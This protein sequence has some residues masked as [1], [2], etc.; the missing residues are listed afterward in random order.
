MG[1]KVRNFIVSISTAV[2][3]FSTISVLKSGQ[4]GIERTTV[5]Y[6]EKITDMS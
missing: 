3:S 1:L 6:G 5:N 2:F 4:N